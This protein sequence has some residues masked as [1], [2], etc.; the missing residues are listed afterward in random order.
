MALA[1]LIATLGIGIGLAA[2]LF[3]VPEIQNA[4]SVSVSVVVVVLIGGIAICLLLSSRASAMF[5]AL[6]FAGVFS[7][8]LLSLFGPVSDYIYL[9][10]SGDRYLNVPD[11]L[12]VSSFLLVPVILFQLFRFASAP[13]ATEE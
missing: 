8:F 4:N 11:L 12:I 5:S 9:P 3:A 2:N 7:N 13:A 10:G 1:G 6:L